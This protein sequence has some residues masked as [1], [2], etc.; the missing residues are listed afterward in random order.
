[1]GHT[2]PIF[3]GIEPDVFKRYW[4]MKICRNIASKEVFIVLKEYED[5]RAYFV[6]PDGGT[7]L[8]HKTE[9]ESFREE[10]DLMYLKE[11]LVISE[12]QY[13]ACR[14]YIEYKMEEFTDDI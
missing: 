3:T 13:Q 11:Y 2:N 7:Q 12:E 8:Y 14:N 5:N 9:F 4:I 1:M 6:S 10:T